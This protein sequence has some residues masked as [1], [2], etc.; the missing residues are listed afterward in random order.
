MH[1]ITFEKSGID[2]PP[3]EKAA[4]SAVAPDLRVAFYV[5]REPTAWDLEKYSE[6]FIETQMLAGKELTSVWLEEGNQARYIFG[7]GGP[8]N[9]W[10]RKTEPVDDLQEVN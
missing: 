8:G 3:H 6:A 2:R 7:D 4:Y 10:V 5:N 9:L 1:V